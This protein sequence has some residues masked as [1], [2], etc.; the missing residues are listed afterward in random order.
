[1]LVFQTEPLRRRRC[2]VIGPLMVKLW[3]S[4]DGPD[5]DF[6]AKLVDV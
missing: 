1:M 5:T 4:S 6:T 2:E 3:A